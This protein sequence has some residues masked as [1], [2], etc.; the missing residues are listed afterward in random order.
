MTSIPRP[1]TGSASQ[2][3]LIIDIGIDGSVIACAMMIPPL[4]VY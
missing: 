3:L 1:A 4:T 2:V